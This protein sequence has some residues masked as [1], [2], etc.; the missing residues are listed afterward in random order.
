MKE[1]K[2][3]EF[4]SIIGEIHVTSEITKKAKKNMMMMKKI[5]T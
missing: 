3:D 5:E 1:Q 2:N 4:K